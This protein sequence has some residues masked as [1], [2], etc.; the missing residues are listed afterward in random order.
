MK[1]SSLDLYILTIGADITKFN[2]Y[3][4]LLIDL[5]L[6]H[7]ETKTDLLMNLFK[8]YLAANNKTFVAYIDRKQE[9]YKEGNGIAT[10]DLMTMADN[11][12]KLLKEGNR[13]NAPLEDEEKILALHTEIKNLQKQA[14][15]A[16]KGN[17]P[18]AT[19]KRLTGRTPKKKG[20][21]K[22]KQDKPDWMS[23]SNKP[24]DLKKP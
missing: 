21:D 6:A 3:V 1:L 9:N 12:F 15:K 7:G 24:N 23:H 13:W 20:Y 17:P 18:A 14:T 22:A 19:K 2:G 11:K 8:G 5:L 4:E 16:K 10:K